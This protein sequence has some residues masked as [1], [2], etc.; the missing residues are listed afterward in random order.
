MKPEWFQQLYKASDIVFDVPVGT[1][2]W[3]ASMFEPLIIGLALPF[4]SKPPCQ[5]R[6]APKMFNLGR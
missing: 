4:I 1:K 5:L 2:C 6:G 3:P